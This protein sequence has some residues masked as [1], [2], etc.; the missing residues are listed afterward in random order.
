[1]HGKR[2]VENNMSRRACVLTRCFFMVRGCRIV[3]VMSTSSVSAKQGLLR[4]RATFD[5][6]FHLNGMA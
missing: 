5:N 1:M 4:V 2:G 6:Y 3:V